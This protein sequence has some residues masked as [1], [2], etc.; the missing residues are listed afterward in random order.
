MIFTQ[1]IKFLHNTLN[2]Y[3]NTLSIRHTFNYSPYFYDGRPD[4]H[5]RHDYFAFDFPLYFVF[6]F[7]AFGFPLSP[8]QT[9]ACPVFF[10]VWY[11]YLRKKV[12][13]EQLAKK[14]PKTTSKNLASIIFVMISWCNTKICLQSNPDFARSQNTPFTNFFA[15]TW[16]GV[17]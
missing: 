4:T 1:Q 5:F 12:K 8:F 15:N 7:R 16:W 9:L 14:Q 2:N 17:L 3:P 10:V 6:K 11:V 13:W